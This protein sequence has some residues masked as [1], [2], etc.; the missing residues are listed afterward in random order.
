MFDKVAIIE[1]PPRMVVDIANF[2]M[3]ALVQ[4]VLD[5]LNSYAAV[6]GEEKFPRYKV[7]LLKQYLLFH[8]K[9]NVSSPLPF[10]VK[11]SKP[12]QIDLS[13]WRSPFISIAQ[14]EALLDYFGVNHINCEVHINSGATNAGQW[15][16]ASRTV[17]ININF[18]PLETLTD[19]QNFVSGLPS[20]EN[21]IHITTAHELIHFVQVLGG[22]VRAYR[23]SSGLGGLPPKSVR[24]KYGPHK[25]PEEKA[26]KSLPAETAHSLK[27]IEFYTNLSD[28]IDVLAKIL[29]ILPE[30]L[31]WQALYMFVGAQAPD[32]SIYPPEVRKYIY[33]Y[34][35]FEHLK[36]HQPAKWKLAVK[37]L[38]NY[39]QNKT[40]LL[41]S[42]I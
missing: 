3:S 13:G 14:L 7:E 31:R 25:S 22:L 40:N 29:Y 32:P 33:T 38:T 27:D 6:L 18:P 37:R 4:V 9:Q 20:E 8:R 5:R 11:L 21:I 28:A 42:R 10:K 30:H 39:M 12:V 16:N 41:P 19:F 35:I 24:S 23:G 34:T 1:A 2:C 26:D 15:I 17:V 36:Q